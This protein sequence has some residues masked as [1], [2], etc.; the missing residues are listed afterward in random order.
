VDDRTLLPAT[1][2][3][4]VITAGESGGGESGAPSSG[5]GGDRETGGSG[6]TAGDAG[7]SGASGRSGAGGTTGTGG[8][9][10]TGGS[11][12]ATGGSGGFVGCRGSRCSCFGDDGDECAGEPCCRTLNVP[13]GSFTLGGSDSS[14]VS[15]SIEGYGLDQFEVTVGRFRKFVDAYL[16][17]PQ[18]DAGQHP[19]VV[20]S[21]WQ[22]PWDAFIAA[23]ADTLRSE[24][25]CHGTQAT[26]TDGV[27]PNEVRPM[28]CVT[29]FEAFAFC[30]WDGGRLPTEAEWEYVASG[31]DSMRVFAWGD[32]E[33]TYELALY[34]CGGVA[35]DECSADEL[36]PV[37]SKPAGAGRFLQ[38][39]LAGSLGEWVLDWHAPYADPCNNCAKVDGG[40]ERVTRGGSFLSERESDLRAVE[41]APEAPT[42]RFPSVG[43]RCARDE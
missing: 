38:E 4:Y 1:G 36:L 35:L 21:G 24:L 41:R 11:D 43:F 13:T 2:G 39:D 14:S 9:A 42:E 15:A 5:A 29:W 33:P 23:D 32:D 28:N 3:T 12:G 30:A 19:F 7:E 31:G 8:N 6:G 37:G 26:W 17:P 16:G 27:G 25:D 34:A 22:S 10:A 20:A 18:P 40:S